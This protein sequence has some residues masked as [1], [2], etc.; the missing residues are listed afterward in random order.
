MNTVLSIKLYTVLFAHDSTIHGS[1]ALFWWIHTELGKFFDWNCVNRLSLNISNII[2]SELL[3]IKL[4][5]QVVEFLESRNFFGV[6]INTKLNFNYHIKNI[7][8]K[9]SNVARV[10][11]IKLYYSLLYPYLL[12]CNKIWV[13]TFDDSHLKT[14]ILLQKKSD[15]YNYGRRFPFPHMYIFF[16]AKILKLKDIHTFIVCNYMLKTSREVLRIRMST[17]LC[18]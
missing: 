9:L 16:Q 3:N 10:N 4:Q 12:Y 6:S 7:C 11:L 8:I 1:S 17:S 13:C 14:V 15:S 5:Y 18:N 2:N